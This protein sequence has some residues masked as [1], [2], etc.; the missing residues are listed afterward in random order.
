MVKVVLHLFRTS[1]MRGEQAPCPWAQCLCR[2]LD[3]AG[4]G[5]FAPSYQCVSEPFPAR[6]SLSRMLSPCNKLFYVFH[7]Q[8]PRTGGTRD[9][10]RQNRSERLLYAFSRA[11]LSHAAALLPMDPEEQT[12]YIW[13]HQQV[14]QFRRERGVMALKDF[15]ALDKSFQQIVEEYMEKLPPEQRL[16]GLSPEERLRGL[17]HE[18][19]ASLLSPEERLRG[20]PPEERLRGLP[21]E[22]RLQGLTPA[23]LQRLKRLLH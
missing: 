3:R 16:R 1:R 5:R 12:V 9:V 18:Q 14:E 10:Y 19:I 8:P 21:P 11:Y 6:H 15:E 7:T 13:L 22:E 23:E 4:D 17:P 20:L 2:S